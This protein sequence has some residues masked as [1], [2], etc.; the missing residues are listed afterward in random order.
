MIQVDPRN[1]GSISASPD[2]TDKS[3]EVV[4]I[5]SFVNGLENE[6]MVLRACAKIDPVFPTTGLGANMAK[7]QYGQYALIATS[8]FVQEPR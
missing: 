2:C 8:V 7:D 1:W 4:P 6:L 3:E 5:R